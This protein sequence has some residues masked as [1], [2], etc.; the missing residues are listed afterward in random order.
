M[1]Y[2]YF[3][4]K[5]ADRCLRCI[6]SRIKQ[7]EVI[8]H[9]DRR[10]NKANSAELAISETGRALIT[11]NPDEKI[12]NCFIHEYLHIFYMEAKEKAI[13][14]MEK[15]LM[16]LWTDRQLENLLSRLTVLLRA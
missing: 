6:Y 1:K 3:D 13:M 4:K 14:T 5:R 8:V 9:L 16:S 7:S 11:I 15:E 10:I 2:R 12:I